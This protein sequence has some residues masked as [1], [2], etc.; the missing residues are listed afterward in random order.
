MD[1]KSKHFTRVFARWEISHTK[2]SVKSGDC[3][4]LGEIGW[5]LLITKSVGQKKGQRKTVQVF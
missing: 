5:E 1:G 2:Q 3:C 4:T